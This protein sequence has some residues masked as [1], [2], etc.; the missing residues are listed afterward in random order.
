ML[1]IG[2]S[3]GIN[4]VAPQEN[5]NAPVM[6]SQTD[7]SHSLWGLWEIYFDPGESGIVIEPLC[8]AQTHYNVNYIIL[9]P[10]CDDCLKIKVN[11]F[12]PDTGILDADVTLRNPLELTGYDVRGIL[13]TDSAGHQLVNAD[14]WV[15]LWDIPGG[16]DINP[17][18]LYAGSEPQWGFAP[19][20][21]YTENY[22]VQMPKPPQYG[23]IT[24]AVDASWPGNCKEPKRITGQHVI[25]DIDTLGLSTAL[26]QVY[27]V[28]WQENVTSVKLDITPLGAPGPLD[29][30]LK[31]GDLWE[32]NIKNE[33]GAAE[34][35]YELW[36]EAVSEDSP[37][38]LYDNLKVTVVPT[39]NTA[40]K[41]DD[42]IGITGTF[43]GD[44]KVTVTYGTATDPQGDAVQYNVYYVDSLDAADPFAGTGHVKLS[45]VG[46]SPYTA[47]GLVNGH[48]Y[49]FGVRVSDDKG[50]E[51][52]NSNVLTGVPAL[53]TPPKWDDTKGIT[54]TFPGD[55]E[56][57]VTYGTA[58]DPQGDA[59][60]YNVYYVDSLDATNPFTGTG[61][62]KLSDVGPSPYTA[63][64][65]VNGHEYYFG[66]RVSDDK[67]AEDNNNMVESGIPNTYGGWPLIW[68]A[69]GYDVGNG[70]AIDDSGN[71]YVTGV[72]EGNV[73][74]DPGPGVDVHSGKGYGAGFFSKFYA[75]GEFQM[76]RTWGGS[77]NGDLCVGFYISVDEF[78][79]VY[80]VGSFTGTADF[81]PGPG[82]AEEASQ[83]GLYSTFLSK[84]DQ[85]GDFEWVRTLSTFAKYEYPYFSGIGIDNLSNVYITGLFSGTTDFDPGPGIDEQ[86]ATGKYDIFLTKFDTDGNFQWARTWGGEDSAQEGADYQESGAGLAIDGSDNV[87][88]A[89][90]FWGTA[91][92]DPGPGIEEHTSIGDYDAF[93]SKYD[94]SGTFQWATTW[95]STGWGIAWDGDS[96]IYV[97]GQTPDGSDLNKFD[98]WGSLQWSK[99][100][101]VTFPYDIALDG[102]GNVWVSGQ[103]LDTADMAPG[104]EVDEH[105]SNGDHDI[106]VSE[107]KAD[108]DFTSAQTWGGEGWDWNIDLEAD[109]SG[110]VYLPGAFMGTVDFDPGPGVNEHTYKGVYDIFL[111]RLPVD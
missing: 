12:D 28:D 45:D 104:P 52:D 51:D 81:D 46:P 10:A 94:S 96:L 6:E 95:D 54:G 76:A 31:A 11:A 97:A 99:S 107:F 7:T 50:A 63:E 35:D 41:W 67:G 47:E 40:P 68:G 14:D 17:F 32:A 70:I 92:F 74:F 1:L 20:A 22:L 49:Y 33:W 82:M 111:A 90:T 65:L 86:T 38:A 53:N 108:G 69:Y 37:I 85:N 57:T 73:D 56:M 8:N 106:F 110:Y 5:A 60:Q 78:G 9:P 55:G 80:I 64:G 48:E 36:F 62:V 105:T 98:L 16:K 30:T 72:F 61:H 34:G 42:T 58:T 89:G 4:P 25:G 75:D 109:D 27:V 39:P 79:N 84:F 26:I 101:G 43:P 29:F 87:Y 103:F 2:C 23:A 71:I 19:G 18:K 93:L 77:V 13:F 66:V 21:M 3:G 24:F 100:W 15:G 102:S 59:V 83:P 44:G 88:V 91:D